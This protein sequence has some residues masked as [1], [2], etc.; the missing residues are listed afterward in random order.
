MQ[1]WI[2]PTGDFIKLCL[3]ITHSEY[4]LKVGLKMEIA[5]KLGYQRVTH[6]YQTLYTQNPVK[7]P[8]DRQRR[9]LISIA[10]EYGMLE[11]AYDDDEN[12]TV[13]WEQ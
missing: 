1:G 11:V 6:I 4:I 12:D 5:Y 2:T 10:I 3:G 8:S 13:L 7:Q 9:N